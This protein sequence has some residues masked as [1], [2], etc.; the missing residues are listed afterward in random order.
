MAAPHAFLDVLA[1][2]QIRDAYLAGRISI[3]LTA[4]LETILWT[5]GAGAHF[6]GMRTVAETI[7][8]ESG[9][10]LLTRHQIEAGLESAK[11]VQVSGIPHS[12]SFLVNQT[13]LSPLGR[14]VFLRS[15]QGQVDD[16]GAAYLIQGLSDET[17]SAAVFDLSGQIMRASRNFDLN[18]FE[19]KELTLVL[20]EAHREQRV[21]KRLS[22]KNPT[23]TIGVLALS[24]DPDILLVIVARSEVELEKEAKQIQDFTFDPQILPLHFGWR[25]DAEGRFEEVSSEL[26]QVVGA[27]YADILG[28]SFA[29][30][31]Q[32][33]DMDRESTLRTLFKSQKAWGNMTVYWP[34]ERTAAEEEEEHRVAITFFALPVTSRQREFVGFRG[35]GTIDE[36]TDKEAVSLLT[37]DKSATITGL[38]EQE[39]QIF[40]IIGR[41]LQA[42][43][44]QQKSPED[45]EMLEEEISSLN[46]KTQEEAPADLAFDIA[47]L[48]IFS[49]IIGMCSQLVS[50]DFN[51][52]TA[53]GQGNG[54]ER[55]KKNELISSQ[56][57]PELSLLQQVPISLLIYRDEKVLF[58]S[59]HLLQMTGFP[60]LDSFR[61]HGVLALILRDW[62]P[63]NILQGAHGE[64]LPVRALM[65]AVN[66]IDGRVASM[67][68]FLPDEARQM[69]KLSENFEHVQKKA[70]ELSAL[71][72]L[73]SDGVLVIDS[74]GLIHSL[75]E[76]A[77]RLLKQPVEE[78][79][80]QNF[81][82]FFTKES[83][84]VLA[85]S[86]VQVG[87]QGYQIRLDGGEFVVAQVGQKKLFL[88][89]NFAPMETDEG[90]YL[91]LRDVSDLH[92]LS[93]QVK[94]LN[95][96]E[97]TSDQQKS[98][99]VSQLSHQIRTPLTA[100]MG[101]SQLILAEKYGPL[102]NDRYRAYLRDIVHSSDHIMQRLN[103]F[104]N[105][106][107]SDHEEL[108]FNLQKLSLTPIVQSVLTGLSADASQR[109]IILRTS[110]GSDVVPISGDERAV[111]QIIVNL[112]K[113]SMRLTPT[114]GQIIVSVQ[115]RAP[116]GVLLRIGDNGAGL[117][118]EEKAAI[119][120][121]ESSRQALEL[122]WQE[123]YDN[124]FS[125]PSKD[126]PLIAD[127]LAMTRKLVEGNG[128]RFHLRSQLGK[129][130]LIE[131]TFALGSVLIN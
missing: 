21:K 45:Q 52:F 66:W 42:D 94:Q 38:T 61:L 113:C 79:R 50:A 109:R 124:I 3:I 125:P 30:L 29:Q 118:E 91:L 83:Q 16:E 112:L 24:Y 128:A 1:N 126:A 33:W 114:G 57:L 39:M 41:T 73:V 121:P 82:T 93:R 62:L 87:R 56:I 7:G 32:D 13:D 80:G 26:K 85:S 131:V 81:Q 34:R 8:V 123:N 107:Q 86:L 54:A 37:P 103:Q 129:G 9:F 115:N 59:E 71:L 36:M 70:I 111:K 2:V 119:F 95:E 49:P 101:L 96:R 69:G 90:Y 17:T 130:M 4:D 75:N 43:L 40:S 63:K 60:T 120:Q 11:P 97:A 117:S 72:N 15:V 20:A 12:Q 92:E 55:E 67:I 31:A 104:D 108:K 76:G 88:H 22:Q 44:Q 106:G 10:D 6:M 58:A 84:E 5:N 27:T 65:R 19:P 35:F 100:I 127:I 110:L 89:V 28:K 74:Q 122:L 105:Q 116:D 68:S 64:S 14:V 23:M 25:V 98:Q 18:W 53:W 48:P 47:Y 78:I 77:A 99:H 51:P 46:G 102:N